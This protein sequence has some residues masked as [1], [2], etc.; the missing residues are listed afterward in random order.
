V[1]SEG[2]PAIQLADILAGAAATAANPVPP[3]RADAQPMWRWL[4]EEAI[5]ARFIWEV[6]VHPSQ[7]GRYPLVLC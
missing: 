7:H 3:T 5:D 2:S 1:E 6:S 4:R